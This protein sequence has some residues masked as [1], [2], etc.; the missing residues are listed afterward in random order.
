MLFRKS[1][2]TASSD[3]LD[4]VLFRW[5]SASDY[6][7][8]DTLASTSIKGIT[9]SGKSSGPMSHLLRCI[10]RHP[11]SSILYIAQKP[12]DK[13][14]LRELF[15]EAGRGDDLIV[16]EEG[17]NA[18]CDFMEEMARAGFDDRAVTDYFV[19]QG[20]ALAAGMG[21]TGDNAKF[22]RLL[23]DRMIEMIV[24]ALRMGAPGG[25]SAAGMRDF[26]ATAAYSND[27]LAD[28]KWADRF[29]NVVMQAASKAAMK[30]PI[31]AA[32]FANIKSFFTSE[33][34]HLDEKPRSGAIAGIQNT[35]H[36]FASGLVNWL[37][38]RGSTIGPAMRRRGKS[39]LVNFPFAT[40]GPTGRFIAGGMKFLWQKHIL[41][42]PFRPGDY[43]SVIVCDEFQESVTDFD[44]RFIS[45]CRSYGGCLL[46]ATQTTS[47]ELA[48]LGAASQHKVAALTANFGHHIFCTCDPAT[49]KV[50]SE[51]SGLHRESF[52]SL[53]PDRQVN[54]Y[55]MLL[56]ATPFQPNYS[57]QWQPRLQ[58]HHFQF[59]L[60]NGGPKNSH[61]VDGVVIRPGMPFKNGLNHQF[62][63]WKQRQR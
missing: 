56:G 40:Y 63:T 31:D 54:P 33:F 49:A 8:R 15:A 13:E 19:N 38:S 6:S 37:C 41:R 36:V 29:H 60:R 5:P 53:S 57:E 61:C 45:Q 28:P 58:P 2:K 11:R 42:T 22:F 25:F 14:E 7:V 46:T 20:E 48:A 62:V 51:M 10:I 39:V 18:R 27:D 9:N 1:R 24:G 4:D 30:N 34:V 12:T 44:F 59:G 50:A 52:I 21:N 55:D 35:G 26:L 43:W 23:E 32:T 17:A 3:P 47:S 16:M